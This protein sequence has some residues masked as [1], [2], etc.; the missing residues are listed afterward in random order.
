[1]IQHTF[2]INLSSRTDRKSHVE[3]QL[4]SI[5]I[6][7]YTRFPAI[8]LPNARAGCS[9]SHLKC[10]QIAETNNWE[11]VLIVEDDIEFVNP[12]V[13]K[14]QLHKIMADSAFFKT[15]DVLLFGGNNIP[16]YEKFPNR[17]TCVKISRCQTTIGY[18]VNRHYYK[19]LIANISEGLEWLLKH[20]DE[21]V[22]YAIDKWWF[23]LQLKDQWYLIIPL[24]VTQRPDFSDIEQKNTNYT[25]LML[26]LDK[27][28][29]FFPPTVM[30][31]VS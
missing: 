23:S 16:P 12:S 5:G 8:A 20:P 14:E 3:S 24:T 29:Y 2:Y 25:K 7:N 26:D 28:A 27:S 9:F 18:L 11:H 19:S 21:H 1:M 10:L 15:L 30:K 17:D 13:F 4:E 31:R 6:L 22:K